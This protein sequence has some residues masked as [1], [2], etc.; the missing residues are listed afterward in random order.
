MEIVAAL[1][2]LKLTLILLLAV[3]SSLSCF[4]GS[5]DPPRMWNIKLDL[6]LSS[7]PRPGETAELTCHISCAKATDNVTV[8]IQLPENMDYVSG[9]LIWRGSMQS[10]SVVSIKST[11]KA[12]REGAG[13][14]K[15]V[16]QLDTYRTLLDVAHLYLDITPA[17]T[18]VSQVPISQSGSAK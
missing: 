2:V 7:A 4:M 18:K 13:E 8:I 17:S 1:K 10:G 16:A 3:V 15:A 14:I 11:V 6:S 5:Q 12:V 9:N